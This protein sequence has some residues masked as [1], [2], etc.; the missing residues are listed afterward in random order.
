M[1]VY[2]TLYLPNICKYYAC[3]KTQLITYLHYINLPFLQW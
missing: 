2:F 3:Y 1:R